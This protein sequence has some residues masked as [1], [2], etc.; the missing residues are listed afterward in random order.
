M[1]MDP[2]TRGHS[3]TGSP[4]LLYTVQ[5]CW[6][7]VEVMGED[8]PKNQAWINALQCWDT[9]DTIDMYNITRTMAQIFC[10][11]PLE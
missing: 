2:V 1:D 3:V 10:L 4:L 7:Q 9:R 5:T 11:G 8:I 6:L